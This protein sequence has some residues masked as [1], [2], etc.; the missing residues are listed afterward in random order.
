MLHYVVYLHYVVRSTLCDAFY[1]G[2][3]VYI[4]GWE[5][6]LKPRE[7]PAHDKQ[8]AAMGVISAKTTFCALCG[9]EHIMYIA[10]RYVDDV[11]SLTLCS[12][13]YINYK[14]EEVA[15]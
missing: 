11:V 12:G 5:G 6:H 15:T 4:F 8:I 1:M 9:F 10:A 14:H 3:Q 13:L 7:Q 2:F